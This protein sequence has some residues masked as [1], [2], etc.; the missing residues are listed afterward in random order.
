MRKIAPKNIEGRPFDEFGLAYPTDELDRL[1][2][3]DM[4]VAELQ[5]YADI[6][7][8]AYPDAVFK[9]QPFDCSTISLES[10]NS[11]AL[12]SIASVS[13][14]AAVPETRERARNCA[15]HA[16]CHA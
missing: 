5:R 7:T 2:V 13:R 9:A 6:V 1:Q 16:A 3:A 14:H 15:D 4:S 10:L 12:A 8:H 11:T